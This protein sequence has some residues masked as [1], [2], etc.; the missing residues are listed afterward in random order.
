MTHMTA[1]KKAAAAAK[2]KNKILSE[3]VIHL[4]ILQSAVC[5]GFS[6]WKRK[7]SSVLLIMRCFFMTTPDTSSFFRV[8]LKTNNEALARALEA[9]KARSSLL[10]K[11]IVYLHKQVEA[12]CFELAT[13]KYKHRKLDSY[14]RKMEARQLKRNVEALI[15]DYI[16]QKLREKSFDPK[17]RGTSILDDLVKMLETADHLQKIQRMSKNTPQIIVAARR[18]S[19]HCGA[20][21]SSGTAQYPNRLEREAM[22]LSSFAGIIM[23]S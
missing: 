15:G 1:S 9:Q 13:R 5:S 6:R 3:C 18:S 12:L 11:E 23:V 14:I 16:G 22:I 21:S 10:E 17:G 8:S 20:T 4:N 19:W 2:I 7:C